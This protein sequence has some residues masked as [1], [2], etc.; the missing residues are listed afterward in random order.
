LNT[1]VLSKRKIVPEYNLKK[2]QLAFFIGQKVNVTDIFPTIIDSSLTILSDEMTLVPDQ[3]TAE[4]NDS[5][6]SAAKASPPPPPECGMPKYA[7]RY[8]YVEGNDEMLIFYTKKLEEKKYGSKTNIYLNG[9]FMCFF[10]IELQI[11]FESNTPDIDWSADVD[12]AS[13]E[14]KDQMVS[15]RTPKFLASTNART[16]VKIILRQRD[17]VLKPLDYFYIQKCN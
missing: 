1:V 3:E 14:V 10:I 4:D 6:E 8:G 13:I 5:P 12:A 16:A 7:P 9:F 11:T 2:A 17:R 15:F